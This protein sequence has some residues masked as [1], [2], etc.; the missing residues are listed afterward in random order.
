MMGK[1]IRAQ[2][3]V[4]LMKVFA[5]IKNPVKFTN[6]YYNYLYQFFPLINF[7]IFRIIYYRTTIKFVWN[8]L[9]DFQNTKYNRALRYDIHLSVFVFPDDFNN[10]NQ[11][12]KFS[13][14]T[15]DYRRNTK[16]FTTTKTL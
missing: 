8:F 4:R 10:R 7:R 11:R 5:D 6:C 12:S 9:N 15:I 3:F 13:Y 2:F 1:V 16:R 14:M